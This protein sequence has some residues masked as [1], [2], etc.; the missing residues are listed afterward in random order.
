MS[1]GDETDLELV[2]RRA[3]VEEAGHA[4]LVG[5]GLLGPEGLDGEPGDAGAHQHRVLPLQRR[6]LDDVL[7]GQRAARAALDV[8]QPSQDD[9]AA[10][11]DGAV[12]LRRGDADGDARALLADDADLE[13]AAGVGLAGE[14]L[15][16]GDGQIAERLAVVGLRGD[17]DGVAPFLLGAAGDGERGG[18]DERRDGEPGNARDRAHG[19]VVPRD[20]ISVTMKRAT[21]SFGS[22]A[23]RR[24]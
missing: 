6:E 21:L 16:D 1:V 14:R 24:K 12:A 5:D 9:A 11:R 2:A 3:F 13:L 23:N 8:G 18:G 10:R 15:A 19:V 22:V 17:D 20:S 7:D 4:L